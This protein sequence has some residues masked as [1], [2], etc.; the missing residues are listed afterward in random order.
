[1][2]VED[3]EIIPKLEQTDRSV[4][5]VVFSFDETY[6]APASVAIAS[7]LQSI[8]PEVFCDVV[9]LDNGMTAESR[10]RLEALA[11][12]SD[13]AA[14]RFCDVSHVAAE[15]VVRGAMSKSTCLRLFVPFLFRTHERVL[16]LDG[17]IIVR[18]DV[19]ELFETEFTDEYVAAVSDVG[20]AEQVRGRAPLWFR[21]RWTNWARYAVR[22]LKVSAENPEAIINAGVLLFNIPAWIADGFSIMR[23]LERHIRS[24]YFHHDQCVVNQLCRGRVK[25]LHLRWNLQV[26][27]EGPLRLV[28]RIAG[29]YREALRNPAIVH[30]ITQRKP[31]LKF[32][33]RYE[34]EF[35]SVASKTGWFHELYEHRFSQSFMHWLKTSRPAPHS[36]ACAE[37]F[38][39]IIMPTL[40]RGNPIELS[41]RSIQLQEFSNFEL[42]VID[43]GSTDETP[44]VVQRL[45]Q[46][47][48]RIKLIRLNGNGGTGP[49]RNIG[50]RQAGGK[51]IRICDSDDFYPPGALSAFARYLAKNDFDVVAGNLVRWDS[52]QRKAV[53][54]PDA[55][56]VDRDVQSSNIRELPELWSLLHFHRCAF[57]RSFLQEK[58]IEYPPLR[59]GEDVTYMA[60]VITTARSFAL[61]KDPVYLFNDRPR[62]QRFA[63][64]VIKDVYA[65]HHLIHQKMTAAGYAD[66]SRFF[67]CFG[68]PFALTHT[69][70]TS[71]QSLELS[72]ELIEF[73]KQIPPEVL[74]N[75]WLK[76]PSVNLIG[77]HHD[78][79]VARS[80]TP[81]IVAELMR[82]GMFC[83][84]ASVRH[85]E[86]RELRQKMQKMRAVLD[87]IR[88]PLRVWR[89]AKRHLIRMR[90]YASA[91][92]R[93]IRAGVLRLI[94]ARWNA[95]RKQGEDYSS[96]GKT[97]GM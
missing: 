85:R 95:W 35:W 32:H 63:Y 68:S 33:V 65:S 40:N 83:G 52:L 36:E 89:F 10:R 29:E 69:A 46:T 73:A 70:V 78:L 24:G 61:I 72:A 21:G 31:W 58:G 20:I 18:K 8:S 7:L 48:A 59:R 55:S 67:D 81:E 87:S 79:L 37:P 2:K 77:L 49:A 43:D 5:T 23:G 80:S 39:S 4:C 14:V 19:A 75:P 38:F 82:R 15:A 30:F 94:N 22:Y 27:N 92:C 44:E 76:Q 93:D 60:D 51:Y 74:D 71:A 6:V 9:V 3:F 66:M 91:L 64:P 47:D 96:C 86:I 16:Y 53:R 45:A 90:R 88:W 11:E 34:D 62:E 12:G 26:Q 1:M 25:Y 13:R 97:D 42:I 57:R 41:I 56:H 50:I 54:D 17:D 28:D 84:P